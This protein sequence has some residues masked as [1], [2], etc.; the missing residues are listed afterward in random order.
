MYNHYQGNTGRVRRVEEHPA[1]SPKQASPPPQSQRSPS[2]QPPMAM[3]P[4]RRPPSPLSGL[5][6][7]MG[8][9]LG[10]LS[11][12]DLD[13]EDFILLLILY[14]MYRESG[15]DE[16]LWMMAGMVFL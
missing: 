8:K 4:L 15:D 12:I 13:T 6:G 7:E 5:S 10:K 14:L 16:L 9:L 3:T 2:K 11:H 1:A